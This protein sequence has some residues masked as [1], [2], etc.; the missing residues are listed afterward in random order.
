[1][2]TLIITLTAVCVYLYICGFSIMYIV[3]YD[4]ET[5]LLRIIASSLWPFCVPMGYVYYYMQCRRAKRAA[6]ILKEYEYAFE[7]YR[8][9]VL[10]NLLNPPP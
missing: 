5:Q 8:D 4:D 1:M 6:R 9:E 7:K 10:R 2:L 3:I